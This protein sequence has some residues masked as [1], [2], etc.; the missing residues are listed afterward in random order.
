MNHVFTAG[1]FYRARNSLKSCH[2][3]FSRISKIYLN[4]ESVSQSFIQRTWLW[5]IF[6]SDNL[7]PLQSQMTVWRRSGTLC[8][9][10]FSFFIWWIPLLL[11]SDVTLSSLSVFVS[12]TVTKMTFITVSFFLPCVSGFLR[13]LRISRLNNLWKFPRGTSVN[14]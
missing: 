4:I 2:Y 14:C 7:C 3:H 11:L 8:F 12:A 9:L 6:C 5:K 13:F 10:L 1:I